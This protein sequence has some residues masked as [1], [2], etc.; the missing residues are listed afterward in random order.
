M[1]V[2][3]SSNLSIVHLD[4]SGLPFNLTTDGFTLCLA[5]LSSNTALSLSHVNLSGW[6][7]NLTLTDKSQLVERL[8][9]LFSTSRIETLQL[10]ACKVKLTCSPRLFS[11]YFQVS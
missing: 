9:K 8:S 4:L 2:A 6:M 5:A 7:F 1:L 3:I 10:A 11:L